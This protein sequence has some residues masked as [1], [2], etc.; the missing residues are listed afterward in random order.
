MTD[1]NDIVV[2]TTQRIFRDLGNAQTLNRA[3][4]TRWREPLWTALQDAGL[5][6]AWIADEFNGAGASMADGFAILQ[7]AGAA[8]SAVP[9][10][11]TLLAGWLLARA[12][13]PVPDGPLAIAPTRWRDQVVVSPDGLLSGRARQVP[14]ASE[15]EHL[16]VL[17]T[18]DGR[19]CVALV[20]TSSARVEPGAS[21][22][23]DA[24]D[25][26][27]LENTRP[28]ALADGVDITRD[29]LMMMGAA[30]RA[31]QMSGALRTALELSVAYANERVA[32]E[33]PI[34]KF[35]VIQHNL[36]R[37]AGETAAALAAAASAA[38]AIQHS[39]A[40][41]AGVM[42]EVASAKIRIG[43]AVSV[44]AG[45]AHQIFGAIGF[46]QEHVLHRY[47]QRLWAWRD[48][49]GSESEWAV[50]L[51][52]SVAAAGADALWPLLASR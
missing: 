8:A 45:I 1:V 39:P 37:L 52:N 4:D 29:D 27:M 13:I 6:R 18:R 51:G 20:P 32:F 15:S 24:L 19:L 26:V 3:R 40:F 33:R 5:T 31:M 11:E 41:D 34:A 25:G 30:T 14:F 38:D 22:A 46:S 10:A 36:A 48:D 50:R 42:L 7:A 28:L 16:A 2:V 17:A 21:V 44:G 12:G 43:E 23:G 9:L 47:T 35:Q 49:F